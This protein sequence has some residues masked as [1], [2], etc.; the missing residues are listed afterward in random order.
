MIVRG[1]PDLH[2]DSSKWY[3]LV[4]SDNEL[5]TDTTVQ[6]ADWII[7]AGLTADQYGASDLKVGVRLSVS[8]AVVGD[9]LDV[10]CKITTSTNETLHESFRLVISTE[11]H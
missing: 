6:T 7:P 10:V 2:P 4:W 3:W 8:T 5:G 11:G 1:I 9:I